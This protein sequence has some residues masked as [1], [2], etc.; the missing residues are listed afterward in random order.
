M[1]E[2]ML[3][4]NK[5]VRYFSSNQKVDVSTLLDKATKDKFVFKFVR[6]SGPG[7]QNVNKLLWYILVNTKVELRFKIASADWLPSH[8]VSKLLTQ[9][10]NDI[11][12]EGELIV[13]SEKSRSQHR[14]MADALQKIRAIICTAAYE[15]EAPTEET[16]RKIEKRIERANEKRLTDKKFRSTKKLDRKSIE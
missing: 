3:R 1:Q 15:P 6:S 16:L 11:N 8:V 2:M 4:V 13:T 5:I 9:A 10:K 12:K 14:N 7:G